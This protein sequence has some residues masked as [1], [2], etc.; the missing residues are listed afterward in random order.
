MRMQPTIA[1][2][3]MPVVEDAERRGWDGVW[4]I[5]GRVVDVAVGVGCE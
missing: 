5:E 1:A 3:L 2:T 4:G